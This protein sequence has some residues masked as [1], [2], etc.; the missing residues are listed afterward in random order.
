MKAFTYESAKE[1]FDEM[2]EQARQGIYVTVEDKDGRKFQLRLQHLPQ[3]KPRRAGSMKGKS[4]VADDF[5]DP[6]P[7]MAPY[8]W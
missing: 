5:D 3:G 6:V 1:N 7:D 8:M 2:M 4:T